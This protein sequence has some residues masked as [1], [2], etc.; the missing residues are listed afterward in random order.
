MPPP[1]CRLTIKAPS[2]TTIEC[3]V[4]TASPPENIRSQLLQY[5]A[6]LVRIVLGLVVICA[7]L[8]KW[9]VAPLLSGVQSRYVE[10]MPWS[11]FGPLAAV[12]MFLVFRRYH[13]GQ[14]VRTSL[15]I[16]VP[17]IEGFFLHIIS[18]VGAKVGIIVQG[19]HVIQPSPCTSFSQT[20]L[21]RLHFLKGSFD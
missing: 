14:L 13:T 20:C 16:L 9:A 2:P 15:A 12:V 17:R 1:R 3:T 10:D 6:V 8:Q 4:S 5:L 19:S 11:R 21:V 18:V 7:G